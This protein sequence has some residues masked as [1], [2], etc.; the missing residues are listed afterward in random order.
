M[1]LPRVALAAVMAFAAPARG[2]E[3]FEAQAGLHLRTTSTANVPSTLVLYDPA[4]RT[5]DVASYLLPEGSEQYG[6][7]LASLRFHGS[8]LGGDLRW[9][10]AAVTGE[11]RRKAFPQTALVCPALGGTGLDEVGSRRCI[12]PGA[13]LQTTELASPITISNGRPIGDELSKTL[14]I[15]EAYAAYTFGKAGFA[16][17]RAGRKRTVIADGFIHD[18]YSTVAELD[19]DLGA[20]G[21]SW[22]VGVGIVQPTRDFVW[23]A[24]DI[25]PVAAR[26]S[27]RACSSGRACSS[28]ACGTGPTAWASSCG[29]ASWSSAPASSRARWASRARR[30]RRASWRGP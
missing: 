30:P 24:S 29:R 21:P 1:R 10:F 2:D 17:V 23:T 19:F 16:T 5:F 14:F 25:S 15:R 9:V 4:L 20:L 22:D 7:F 3:A 12:G 11:V 6:S 26:T 13:P 28:S 18:D 8:L 27:S